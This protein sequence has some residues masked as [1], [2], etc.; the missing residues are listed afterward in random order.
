MS[1]LRDKEIA[2]DLGMSVSW[3]RVQRHRRRTGKEH[4]L[5]IDPVFIGS[6]PRYR[7]EDYEAWK[8]TLGKQNP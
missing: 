1:F 7:R 4:A 6:S 5:S 3:V 8:L 2:I